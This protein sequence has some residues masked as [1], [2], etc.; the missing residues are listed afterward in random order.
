MDSGQDVRICISMGTRGVTEHVNTVIPAV[1]IEQTN[2]TNQ[3]FM[4]GTFLYG[5]S[6]VL[7]F[8]LESHWFLKSS[9]SWFDMHN[10]VL[11]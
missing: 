6:S 8:K 2:D 5:N 1:Y 3:C 11:M 7:V 9:L 10:L 4:L